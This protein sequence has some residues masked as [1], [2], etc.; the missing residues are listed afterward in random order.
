MS[1]TLAVARAEVAG[2]AQ[3]FISGIATGG[4]TTTL[5]DA[6]AL[7]HADG[8]WDET[9]VLMLSGTNVGL[10]R[11]VQTFTAATS[12]LNFYSAMTGAVASGN[13]RVVELV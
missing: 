2:R 6:N 12:T 1:V 7:T 10:Q 11:R 5:A 8:Y 9:T 3:E 13:L 4:S